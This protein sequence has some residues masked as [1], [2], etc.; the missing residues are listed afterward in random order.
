MNYP[1][2]TNQATSLKAWSKPTIKVA[3]VKMTN[4]IATSTEVR[5]TSMEEED[6]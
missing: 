3:E 5:L 4:I 6:W 2:T 1:E